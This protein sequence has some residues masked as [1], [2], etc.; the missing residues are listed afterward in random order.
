MVLGSIRLLLSTGRTQLNISSSSSSS[1]GTGGDD[2]DRD[3]KHRKYLAQSEVVRM[4]CCAL[5]SLVLLMFAFVVLSFISALV[6]EKSKWILTMK[7]QEKYAGKLVLPALFDRAKHYYSQTETGLYLRSLSN[8]ASK[9]DFD[10]AKR[11]YEEQKPFVLHSM[12]G[13]PL[14]AHFSTIKLPE[15]SRISFHDMIKARGEMLLE[16][17]EKHGWEDYKIEKDKCEMFKFLKNN[18]LP[19]VDWLKIYRPGERVQKITKEIGKDSNS[20]FS[21]SSM[22]LK[23]ITSQMRELIK[24]QKE[25][26]LYIKSCHITTGAAK[27]V[28]KIHNISDVTTESSWDAIVDW[29]QRMWRYRSNDW[30][31]VWAESFNVLCSRI[32]PGFMVQKPWKVLGTKNYALEI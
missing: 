18:G 21:S 27:S 9:D 1:V 3:S 2:D 17:L 26:P 10:H 24:K 22:T 28:R 11:Y 6:H 31:R 4:S 19:H 7:Q 13:Y 14:H 29:A 12:D 32:N 20:T 16:N 30:E 23:G 25:F 8:K 5:K 15:L